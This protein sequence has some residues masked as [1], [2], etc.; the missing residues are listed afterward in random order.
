MLRTILADQ[1][2]ETHAIVAGAVPRDA[3]KDGKFKLTRPG[4]L[5]VTGVR[6]CGKSTLCHQL[7]RGSDYLYVN[8]DDERL[9]SLR[10]ADLQLVLDALLS[11]RPHTKTLLLDEVQ[12]VARWELFVNRL[13]RGGYRL[14]VTGSNSRL[15]SKE[16][17]THLTG[18]HQSLELFPFSFREVLLARAIEPGATSLARAAV[19]HELTRYLH[20][21]G[22]PQQVLLGYQAGEL[23]DL[24]D[25]IVSRD[26]VLRRRLRNPAVI[27]ELALLAL[28]YSAQTFT[29]Q[30]NARVLGLKGATTS[31]NYLEYLEEAYLLATVRPYSAKVKEQIRLPRKLYAIDNG[32]LS[33][34][35]TRPTRD[36][37]LFLETLVHQELR[38]RGREIWT[39]LTPSCSVDFLLREGRDVVELIQSCWSLADPA[40]ERRELDALIEAAKRTRCTQ[41]TVITRDERG[42]RTIGS[43]RVSIVPI[44]DWLLA[45]RATSSAST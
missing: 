39:Y 9:V 7:L 2:A 10:S 41:L 18:R 34:L 4:A 15:L 22:F 36:D 11:L 5:V 43:A 23:R 6:R 12:N 1:Q 31:K 17:A 27:K 26:V 44:A 19:D 24:Y 28:S 13:L 21:G 38:R 32:M 37:G 30:A 25:R 16:L 14:V 35:H 20:E 29:H 8:F 3:L 45:D 40:T 33:A 42:E